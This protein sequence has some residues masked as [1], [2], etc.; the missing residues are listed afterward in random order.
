LRSPPKPPLNAQAQCLD[1]QAL[2]TWSDISPV[3]TSYQVEVS[4]NSDPYSTLAS[5]TYNSEQFIY[6]DLIPQST[7]QFRIRA[8][9]DFGPSE[10]VET[11]S[12]LIPRIELPQ[13][14]SP[15]ISP[16]NGLVLLGN[17]LTISSV[18][19]G[20]MIFYTLDDSL[21]SSD[22]RLPIVN[23]YFWGKGNISCKP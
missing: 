22:S 15:Q 4:V 7:I 10:W 8:L 20:A 1:G 5:L 23:L 17:S 6:E 16:A 3:E 19:P 11:N 12:I 18:T 9:N 13:T 14:A 21:P 2:V